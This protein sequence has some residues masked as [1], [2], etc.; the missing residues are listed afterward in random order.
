AS[1]T[2][3]AKVV[4]PA[5][6]G[7]TSA[8]I[9]CSSTSCANRQP[10]SCVASLDLRLIIIGDLVAICLLLLKKTSQPWKPL[11]LTRLSQVGHLLNALPFPNFLR[12]FASFIGLRRRSEHG[13]PYLISCRTKL[14]LLHPTTETNEDHTRLG[15]AVKQSRSHETQR[16]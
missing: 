9:A 15:G 13:T 10:S 11:V 3:L 7:P 2:P 14:T 16:W 5:P 6:S 4:L 12:H 8:T 1:P